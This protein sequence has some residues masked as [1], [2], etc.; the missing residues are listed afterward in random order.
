MRRGLKIGLG[1][2]GL[3]FLFLRGRRMGGTILTYYRQADARW[4]FVVVGNGGGGPHDTI[5]Y[6]GCMITSL[7]MSAGALN[8]TDHDWSPDTV[9]DLLKTASAFSGVLVILPAAAAALDMYAPD[10]EDEN[11]FRRIH[12]GLTG[13]SSIEQKKQAMREMIDK[14]LDAGGLLLLNVDHTF[15]GAGAHFIL[16][17]SKQGGVYLCADPATGDDTKIDVQTL[18]NPR[19]MWGNEPVVYDAVGVA[20]LFKAAA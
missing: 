19:V 3:L 18:G 1:V 6:I 4:H 20:P 15:E 7:G 14:V 17:H 13:F 10:D 12:G 5:G 8:G 16:L 9:N 2:A 11:G